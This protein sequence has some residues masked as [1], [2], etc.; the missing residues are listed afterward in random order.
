ML[1]HLV[2]NS[3]Y[4]DREQAQPLFQKGWLMRLLRTI[5]RIR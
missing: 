2:S 3:H 1:G 4:A 5:F